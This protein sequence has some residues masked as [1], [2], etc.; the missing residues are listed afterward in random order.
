M[1]DSSVST[2][3]ALSV[4]GST[5]VFGFVFGC[6]WALL[7]FGSSVGNSNHRDKEE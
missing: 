1:I 7:H 2:V 6:I 5:L 4:A 3:H